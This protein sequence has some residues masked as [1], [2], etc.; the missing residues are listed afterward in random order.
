MKRIPA[1]GGLLLAL[2]CGPAE[3]DP[4]LACAALEERWEAGGYLE[5]VD[6]R[7]LD[8]QRDASGSYAMQLE[9]DL[10]VLEDTQIFASGGLVHRSGPEGRGHR[11]PVGE[12]VS[13]REELRLV[14]TEDGWTVAE[15]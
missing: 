3:P 13:V 9:L 15:P 14:E 6:C 4:A 12:V 8:G 7:R 5:L 10:E 1:L 2:A 11:R